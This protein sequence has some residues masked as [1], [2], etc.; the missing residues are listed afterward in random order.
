MERKERR[1]NSKL[2]NGG[3]KIASEN[4]SI[5]EMGK[6]RKNGL[7][8]ILTGFKQVNYFWNQLYFSMNILP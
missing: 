5:E 3:I 7:T 6:E 4:T 8:K 1:E 2:I